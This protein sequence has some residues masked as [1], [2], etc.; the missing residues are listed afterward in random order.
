[1]FGIPSPWLIGGAV[2]AAVVYTGIVFKTGVNYQYRIDAVADLKAEIA[3]L[4]FDAAENA[5]KAKEADA[6]RII[7]EGNDAANEKRIADLEAVLVSVTD[8]SVCRADDA[9][10]KR[11][12]DIR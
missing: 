5:R 9:G 1:M 2:V 4:H 8:G 10:I 12:L 6:D 11:L 7:I 3:T